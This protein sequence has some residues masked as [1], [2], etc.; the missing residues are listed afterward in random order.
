MKSTQRIK[1]NWE[2][3]ISIGSI[4]FGESIEPLIIK[5]GLEKLE[6]P[7]EECNW[8]TYRVFNCNTCLYSENSRVTSA[9]CFDNLYY[10]GQNLFGITIEEVRIILGK[11]SEIGEAMRYYVGEE[12]IEQTPVEFD[13]LSLQLWFINGIVTSAI[14]HPLLEDE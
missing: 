13:E 4:M 7:F 5:F 9:G 12:E 8:E 11:E 6:K 3:L 2:P 10:K 1:W 14:V